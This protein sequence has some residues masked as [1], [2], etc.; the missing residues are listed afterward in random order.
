MYLFDGKGTGTYEEIAALRTKAALDRF[1]K[2]LQRLE[3]AA[4]VPDFNFSPT[5]RADQEDEQDRPASANPRK[6]SDILSDTGSR[7]IALHG[8]LTVLT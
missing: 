1:W 7:G 3:K 6:R 5:S 2:R 4:T 8:R